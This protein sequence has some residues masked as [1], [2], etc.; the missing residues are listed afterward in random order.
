MLSLALGV[1]V[2]R[3][4]SAQNTVY[5]AVGFGFINGVLVHLSLPISY[6]ELMS[7]P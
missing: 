6:G 1:M 3:G 2:L 5:D 7:R 4:V